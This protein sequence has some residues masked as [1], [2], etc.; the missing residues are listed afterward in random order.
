[1][2]TW[3]LDEE[4]RARA[5]VERELLAP[6]SPFEVV[7][8]D[9]LGA[10]LSVF[11]RRAPHLRALLS[12]SQRFGDSPYL[13]FPD[14]RLSFREHLQ[15]VSALAAT[16][17]REY[18]IGK[19]D[20]VAI[21]GANAPEWCLAFWATI[22]LGAIAVAM[23][24]WWVG[25]EIDYALHQTAPKLLVID[26]KRAE[27]LS[28]PIPCGTSA[29]R[30]SSDDHETELEFWSAV[31]RGR[32]AA[33]SETAIEEDDAAIL[34]FTSGTT[35]RPKGALHSH[36]N[37]V[38]LLGVQFFHGARLAKLRELSQSEAASSGDTDGAPHP[39]PTSQSRRPNTAGWCRTL[40]FTSRGSTLR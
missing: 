3:T 29:L 16:F 14:L 28:R 30:F 11:K 4:L 38:A 13:V 5:I 25:D 2:A 9:V 18:G 36:R 35:G 40:C 6:G 26:H 34:L 22:S 20:R 8:E 23:N 24:G 31:K 15:A 12:A 32:G 7:E 21:L 39:S 10:R 33:L 17:E 37:V 19:G 1:M 27:R